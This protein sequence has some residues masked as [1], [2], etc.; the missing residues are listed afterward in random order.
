MPQRL[1]GPTKQCKVLHNISS[2]QWLLVVLYS[3]GRYTKDSLPNPVWAIQMGRDANGTENVPATFMQT[4]NNLFEDML[5]Q[6]VVVFLNDVLIYSTT[7]EGHFK[8]LEKMFVCLQK[9]EFYCK[10]KKCSFLWRTTTFLGFDISPEGLQISNAKIR[11][12][13]EWPKPTTVQ[14]VQSFLGFVQFL[15]NL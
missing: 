10:L 1:N 6:G 13:K 5:D 12:L 8:L 4:M 14:Q 11:S 2:L 3:R 9:Y 15:G 7:S